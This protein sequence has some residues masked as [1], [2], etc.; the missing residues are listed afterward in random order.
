[1]KKHLIFL[2]FVIL[3]FSLFLIIIVGFLLQTNRSRVV[4]L[5]LRGGQQ[6]DL[7]DVRLEKVVSHIA[8][9]TI[10]ST[11]SGAT[12]YVD[13]RKI[14]R[15]PLQGHEIDTGVAREKQVEVRL[16]FP[17][18]RS[19]VAKLTLKG[20][21][22]TPW[23]VRLEKIPQTQQAMLP[24]GAPP[25]GMA[26]IPAGEFQMG[27]NE[28]D[29]DETPV[30]TV[31]VDAFYMDIYEV[32][33]GQY[34]RFVRETGHR[35]PNWGS[36]AEYSP[37]KGHPMISVSW[38]DA[39]AYA[40]WAGKRLPT[41]AEWEKAARGGLVGKKYP[42]GDSI[43]SSKAKY[44][45]SSKAEYNYDYD[46]R[47]TTA[48]GIYP[49][50]GYGLYDMASNVWEWC[51]DAYNEDF[52]KNS[53]RENPVAEVDSV[54]RLTINFNTRVLRGGSWINPPVHL[55]VTARRG[56]S[57]SFTGDNVGFRCAKTQ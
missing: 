21:Q 39:M 26:L 27:S 3:C 51:L 38:Y 23:D 37:T 2:F 47:N 7:Q 49:P 46:S 6:T 43:D 24:S 18:Y 13:G 11:P 54:T 4:P 48:V 40:K 31:Y 34:L 16:D 1:M 17:D 12:I 50:N 15:T 36:V 5:T 33:T 14:G 42:W 32:T 25:E 19:Q 53:T 22:E 45:D 41:E 56:S 20:G 9:L 28:G 55:R 10:A 8:T 57:P 52:Y 29:S 30:H 35:S 44:R